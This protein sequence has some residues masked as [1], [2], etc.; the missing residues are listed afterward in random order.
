MLGSLV[1]ISDLV[2][3]NTSLILLLSINCYKKGL[4]FVGLHGELSLGEL[5]KNQKCNTGVV[6]HQ[7][8]SRQM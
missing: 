2:I 6:I 4:F 7:G 3:S 5:Y 1:I 8:S